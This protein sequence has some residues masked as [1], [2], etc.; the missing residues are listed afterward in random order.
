MK[1]RQNVN[2]EEMDTEPSRGKNDGFGLTVRN[3]EGV[4]LQYIK[5]NIVMVV[6][7]KKMLV[8]FLSAD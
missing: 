7:R 8:Q 2:F 1:C 5:Q 6:F 3:I 4:H